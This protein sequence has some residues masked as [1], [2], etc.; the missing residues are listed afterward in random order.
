MKKMR[1]G[2]AL[3]IYFI[4]L[5]VNNKTGIIFYKEECGLLNKELKCNFLYENKDWI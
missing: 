5:R 4:F 1:S 3:T 2:R